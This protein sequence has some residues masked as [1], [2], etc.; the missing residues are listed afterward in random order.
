VAEFVRFAREGGPTTTS[1]VA[2]REAVA[3]GACATTSLRAGGGAVEVPALDPELAAWFEGGQSAGEEPGQ[4]ML[5]PSAAE[6][7]VASGGGG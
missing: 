1:P 2:A 6:A 7:S 3:A 4:A 5:G